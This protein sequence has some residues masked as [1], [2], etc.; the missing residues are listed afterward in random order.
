[1][2][3][4]SN[5]QS[6]V[7]EFPFQSEKVPICHGIEDLTSFLE[8]YSEYKF[9]LYLADKTDDAW[10]VSTSR[11]YMNRVIP[12][13]IYLPVNLPKDAAEDLRAFF[14]IAQQREDVIAV[15]ITQPHKS[16]V[17]LREIFQDQNMPA[18]VDALVKDESGKLVPFD[19]NGPSF[20]DWYENEVGGVGDKTI[21]L[22]GVGGVGE[23]LARAFAQKHPNTLIL[24]DPNDKTALKTELGDNVTAYQQLDP[25][26]IPEDN[27][28]V[29][30]A[31]GKEGVSHNSAL[32]DILERQ[33]DRGSIFVD[34]RPHL[35]I[36]IVQKAKELGWK[37]YTGY[38]MNAR[39]DYTLLFKIAQL[40]HLKILSFQKFQQ[41]V[42]H[43]S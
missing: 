40:F 24:V 41:L 43:A 17:V 37:S 4:H 26:N 12:E 6:S 25:T 13:L 21:L 20:V 2:T 9:C 15:N 33:K 1:M 16:N 34:L 5:M 28:V 23:P 38:G 19:L 27:L 31:A 42:A 14:A 35:N 22:I 8:K 7:K 30:N 3:E 36:E 32:N 10:D 39:N 29:I 11:V 18:N